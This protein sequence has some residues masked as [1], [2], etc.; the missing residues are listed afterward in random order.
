MDLEGKTIII[1]R[2]ASQARE[3]RTRLED[4]G[5]KVIECPT[6]QIVPPDDWSNVDAAVRR[7]DSYNWVLFTSSNAVKF[8][9]KR[10]E[11][12]GD[13]CRIPIAV[14]GSSTAA[15]LQQWN[16]IPALIPRNF[17][18]EGLLDAM[19]ENLSGLKILLPRAETAREILPDELRRRG[20]AVDIVTVYRSVGVDG[21]SPRIQQIL[22]SQRIDCIVFTSPSTIH[23]LAE[24]LEESLRQVLG[25]IPIAVIGPVTRDAAEHLGLQV[26]I[27]PVQST[28]PDL[29]E[30]IAAYFNG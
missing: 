23:F 1:T 2:A 21:S 28:V 5:A 17:R 10:V 3:L 29:V 6:I 24:T 15:S 14:V 26:S 25:E 12:A 8:F 9:M 16:L 4:R 19:A 22:S 18:A 11:A 20:A 13:V 27:S 7:L 30:A